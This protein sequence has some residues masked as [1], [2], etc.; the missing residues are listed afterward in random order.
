MIYIYVI[1]VCFMY[2]LTTNSERHMY[3]ANQLHSLTISDVSPF[4]RDKLRRKRQA[5]QDFA[6]SD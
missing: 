2:Y 3:K 4:I 6:S 1:H 5:L